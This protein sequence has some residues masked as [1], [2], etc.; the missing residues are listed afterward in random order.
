MITLFDFDSGAPVV[1]VETVHEA[2]QE[3]IEACL[4]GGRLFYYEPDAG[5]KVNDCPNYIES[6]NRGWQ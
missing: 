6:L 5:P 4:W 2:E 3:V 1:S